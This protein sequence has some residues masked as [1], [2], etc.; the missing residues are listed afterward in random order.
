MTE[1]DHEGATAAREPELHIDD[2][3]LFRWR[4]SP[5]FGPYLREARNATGLSLRKVAEA[6]GVSFTYL[7]KL[8][9]NGRYKAPTPELLTRVARLYGLQ[10][11]D[12]LREGGIQVR[13]PAEVYV[14]EKLDSA[15]ALLVMDERLRPA[16]M[17]EKWL[18][19]LSPLHKQQWVEFAQKLEAVVT[20]G[21]PMLDSL[22]AS[23]GAESVTTAP[24][25]W[26]GDHTEVE[27]DQP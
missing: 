9:T 12:V 15:F 3:R 13:T 19:S 21:G 14:Q 27:E 11:S 17:D 8:E 16:G 7:Q 24:K 25:D 20:E 6:V 23:L 26:I 18:L 1:I 5:G 2:G 22:L 4:F 10:V